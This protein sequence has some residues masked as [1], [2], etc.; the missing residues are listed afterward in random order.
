MRYCTPAVP[1]TTTTAAAAITT[2]AAAAA[3]AAFFPTAPIP[4]APTS[5]F[6]TSRVFHAPHVPT[7]RCVRRRR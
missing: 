1:H 5:L 6:R 3:A 2:T 4:T 7:A